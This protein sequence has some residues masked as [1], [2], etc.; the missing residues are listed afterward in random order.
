MARKRNNDRTVYVVAWDDA[1]IV[2]IGFTNDLR[3]RR[4][5]FLGA[6]LVLALTF[7]TAMIAYDFESQANHAAFAAWP[8]AFASSDEARSYISDRA[9]GF[10]ECY[11]T[12]VG[13]VLELIAS[14]CVVTMPD[15]IVTPHCEVSL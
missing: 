10:L 1:G 2:K 14:Q 9:R 4:R 3:R 5:M 6:R 15:R 11:R 8:R 12:T 7:P 13:E